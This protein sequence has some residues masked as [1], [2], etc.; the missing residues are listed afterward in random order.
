MKTLISAAAVVALAGVASAQDLN[1]FSVGTLV[2][3]GSVA[4]STIGA[5]DNMDFDG[6]GSGG[7]WSGGDVV[8]TVDW[9][10]GDFNVD[11]LFTHLDGD[12]DMVLF[13][14]ATPDGFGGGV[15]ATAISTDDNENISVAGLAA[16]TYWL[17]IDGWLGAANDYTIVGLEFVPAPASAGLLGLGGLMAARRRR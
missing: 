5:P 7:S 15:V 14:S 1:D 16:G 3:G 10:G 13:D 9:A 2:A 11:L 8:Y 6:I 4:G 12:I 17:S